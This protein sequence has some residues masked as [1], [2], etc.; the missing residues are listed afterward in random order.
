AALELDELAP[1][2][3]RLATRNASAAHASLVVDRLCRAD[4]HL[5]RIAATQMAGAAERQMVDH[6]HPPSFCTTSP[7]CDLSR[8]S[9]SDRYKIVCC[10][11]VSRLLVPSAVPMTTRPKA[12]TRHLGR[13]RLG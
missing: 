7:S 8:R 3:R 9:C 5:L 1:R 10:G 13:R 12:S 11:H 6:R 4:E 2:N